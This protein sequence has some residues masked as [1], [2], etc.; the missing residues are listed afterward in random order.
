A[1]REPDRVFALRRRLEEYRGRLDEVG[2][3]SEQLGQPYTV[4][5][6]S[7]YVAE[8]LAWLALGLPL[9]VWGMLCHL[10]P[11]WLTALAV[12]LIGGTEEEEATDKM[13][14]GAVL[15][16]LCWAME[17]WLIWRFLGPR[18]AVV[19]AVLLIPSGLLALAWRE[20][21]DRVARQARAFF[22]FL[23]E[24]DLH[25]KLMAERRALVDEVRVLAAR[26]PGPA[27]PGGPRGA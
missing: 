17:G 5:L 14:A 19:F 18:V 26:I 9:A 27:A 1:E 21:L 12:P 4:G 2:I 24:R 25:R 10:V 7:R 23:G 15:Y 20:R 16:P 22:R 13:A 3:T 8:N 6:V 11:Y